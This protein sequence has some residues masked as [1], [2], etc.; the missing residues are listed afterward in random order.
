MPEIRSFGGASF[1][2]RLGL[3]ALAACTAAGCGGTMAFADTS[4]IV[5]A[6]EGPPPP[7]PPPPPPPPEPKRV[8]VTADKIVIK[9]KIQFD[10]DKTTIKPESNGLLDEI[11]QVIKDNPR[12]KKISIEGHTDGD[13]SDKYNL[14][15]SDGRAK[16]VMEYLTTHGVEAGRLSAKG[17][18]ESKPLASN[19]TP[20]GKEQNRRVEFLIAEQ[21]DMTK[22]YEID[23]KT[24]K[25]HEV[26]AEKKP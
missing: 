20:E 25:R 24:G 12:I 11:T 8:E 15:L 6:G 3:L 21:E 9:E 19:D 17:Y 13:G 1:Y 22:T 23:P 7:E 10:V 18:G 14:K 2:G 26:E 16:A 4:S 5:V